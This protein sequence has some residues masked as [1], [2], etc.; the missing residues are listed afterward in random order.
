[1]NSAARRSPPSQCRLQ[2]DAIRE[3]AIEAAGPAAA[4]MAS[5]SSF[6]GT[7]L[8]SA[9]FPGG[10]GFFPFHN[11]SF[12]E[13]GVSRTLVVILTSGSHELY[14]HAGWNLF[15]LHEIVLLHS[16][17]EQSG[18]PRVLE[19]AINQRLE[20]RLALAHSSVPA[21]LVDKDDFIQ[22]LLQ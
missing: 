1:M 18:V 19:R 5:G 13:S 17:H 20:V 7:E 2:R 15:I 12:C 21:T 10:S 4:P 3:Q 16:F 14:P 6:L 11:L 9:R 8:D 22:F